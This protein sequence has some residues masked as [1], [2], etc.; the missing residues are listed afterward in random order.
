M[1]S[2]SIA[3]IERLNYV[4]GGV[5]VVIAALAY[6]QQR[7]IA[8][9]FAI[10]VVLTCANFYV[11]RK[12]VVKWTADAAA[13]RTGH[14]SVLMLPKMLGLMGLVA[15][16]LIVLPIDAIAFT[17]GYSVFIVSIVVDTIYAATRADLPAPIN[18]DADDKH[19]G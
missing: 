9:G 3:R 7:E 2:P 1:A 10:G 11:L 19:H 6:R 5:L 8:L 16:S 4:L 18:P 17:A 13:G 15:F 14:S 12:L